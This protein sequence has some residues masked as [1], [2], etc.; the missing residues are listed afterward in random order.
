MPRHQIS[1]AITSNA[2]PRQLLL[3]LDSDQMS[4]RVMLEHLTQNVFYEP[5]TSHLLGSVL[6]PG[7]TFIDVGAHVGYFSMLASCLVGPTGKV[8]SF[9][10]DL[11]N[12]EHLLEHIQM[13]G[14][15]HVHPASM[16]VGGSESVA[17][18]WVNDDND[19]GHALW[20]VGNHPFN[21]KSRQS[22][23]TRRVF[24]TSLD[25]F[26]GNRDLGSLKAIKIDAEGAEVGVLA[27]ARELLARHRVPFI[28]AEVNRFGLEAM[29]A[30]E[31]QLRDLMT[32]LGY[33]TYVFIPGQRSLTRLHAGQVVHTDYVFNVLF[34]HPLAPALAA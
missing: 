4:Q 31:A 7:D 12:H 6:Q 10:P 33:E 34:R 19:G 28:V 3:S 21:E 32:S 27:G 15:T 30:S 16:A 13:N 29:G 17:E 25:G 23:R 1:I 20:N 22:Q 11:R 24:M 5:E 26:F 8:F 14:A 2:G 9:E 18:F